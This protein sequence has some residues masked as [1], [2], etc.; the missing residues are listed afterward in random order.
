MTTTGKP[1]NSLK[2]L[3]DSVDLPPSA[4]ALPGDGRKRDHQCCQ[5]KLLALSLARYA[6][7]DG[8]SC[9]P[10]IETLVKATGRSRR[11]IARLLDDLRALGV[12]VDGDLHPYYKTRVRSLN[13]PVPDS[14]ITCARL[15]ESPVPDTTS[16][17]PDSRVTTPQTPQ[18]GTRTALDLPLSSPP[19]TQTA[20][21]PTSGQAGRP[22]LVRA[23]NLATKPKTEA[24][25]WTEFVTDEN[26]DLPYEMKH[27]APTEEERNKVL[28]QL[29]ALGAENLG[30]AISEWV[31]CNP[32]R[33]AV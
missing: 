31:V 25:R 20:S 21:L 28:T 27:A 4:F 10:S 33:F 32:L 12:I 23:K 1:P 22:D 3:I 16:P 24:Q 7:P 30:M 19:K 5:R 2:C 29:D 15:D 13:L 9:Y 26:A 14:P 18:S 17:V 6:N 8:T 11:T